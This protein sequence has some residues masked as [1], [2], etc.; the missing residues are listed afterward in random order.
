MTTGFERSW[1]RNKVGLGVWEHRGKVAIVGYGYSGLD[2]RWDGVSMDRTLG[3]FQ[4]DAMEK[5]IADAGLKPED[6]D[7][8]MVCPDA[9]GD[10]W[11]QEDRGMD[12]PYFD[13]P[14]DSE[15]GLSFT[16]AK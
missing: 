13:P 9:A 3:A 5:A 15:D 6:I 14:Y 7:G 11:R 2:R 16:S 12:R 8:L 4:A 10:T 1:Q